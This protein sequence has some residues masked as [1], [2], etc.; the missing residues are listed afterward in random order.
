MSEPVKIFWHGDSIFEKLRLKSGD[1]LERACIYL[2]SEMRGTVNRQGNATNKRAIK[3]AGKVIRSQPGEPPMRQTGFGHRNIDYRMNSDRSAAI[4]GVLK[5]AFYMA[6]LEVGAPKIGLAARPW[7]RPTWE[8][9]K[10]IVAK[11][12]AGKPVNE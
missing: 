9:S 5:P 3:K 8:R 6:I 12:W 10:P 4:V 2:K 11:I 1:N 7:M